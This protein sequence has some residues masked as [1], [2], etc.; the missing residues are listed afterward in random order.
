MA[1]SPD[2]T[3]LRIVGVVNKKMKDQYPADIYECGQLTIE[4]INRIIFS[5]FEDIF[6]PSK[7]LAAVIAERN[8]SP[9]ELSYAASA[10]IMAASELLREDGN[11]RSD[12]TSKLVHAFMS[13][14]ELKWNKR[15]P[16]LSFVQLSIGAF[17]T[18]EV[19]KRFAYESLIMSNR[20][21]M[22]D[23]RGKE[24]IERIFR[25][26]S[27]DGGDK[28][29]PDDVRRSY[30]ASKNRTWQFRTISDF[31]ASM[32][33]RYCGEFYS[34]LTGNMAPTIYKPF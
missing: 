12:F 15:R 21:K 28:V 4:E 10:E 19:L 8:R 23:R 11:M 30:L 22:V 24:I 6:R 33:D 7:E 20:F 3:K 25:V 26:L 31:V 32:T 2:A 18:I 1:A 16:V 14:I 17:Q 27:E 5:I 29:M 9:E 13:S 34:R